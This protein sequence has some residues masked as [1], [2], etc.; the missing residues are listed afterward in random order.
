[1][2]NAEIEKEFKM[3]PTKIFETFCIPLPVKLKSFTASRK[4]TNVELK[5]T[6]TLEQN[7]SGFELQR[8]SGAGGWQKIGFVNSK[9]TD[10]NSVSDL[11]YTYTDANDSRGVSQ[12][13]L[14]QVDL[15]DNAKYSEIRSVQGIGQE[16]RTI[17]SPNPSANGR[18]SVTFQSAN[19]KKDLQLTDMHGRMLKQWNAYSDNSLQITDL[20]PGIYQLR[21]VD[22]ETGT[23]TVEKIMVV[24]R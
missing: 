19:S 5:W 15:D 1:M 4:Q 2:K 24:N 11:H 16:A 14:M 21:I 8:Q 3:P 10:G 12:Y 23:Q 9:A 17:I 7:N 20:T 18:V 13:R 6:T 22:R